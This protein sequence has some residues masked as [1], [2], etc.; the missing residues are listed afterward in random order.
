MNVSD[1]TLERLLSETGAATAAQVNELKTEEATSGRSLQELAISGGLIS[2]RALAEKYAEM[3]DVAFVEIDPKT[4]K[5][6]LLAL[7]P[8]PVAQR[9][10]AV[11]Y[12][13]IEDA[14]EGTVQLISYVAM[15]DPEDIQAVGFLKKLLGNSTEITLATHDNIQKILNGLGGNVDKKLDAVI[16]TQRDEDPELDVAV[17]EADIKEDSPTAQTVNLLIE[18]AIRS[19]ASDIHI[20]PN[21]DGVRV[22]YRIDGVLKEANRLPKKVLNAVVSRIKILANL[23]ID[24]RR[25]PQDG[26]F[27]TIISNHQYA[28]RVST[29]PVTEGE[30]VVMRILD[31]SSTAP[32][33][34]QLGYWG[35]SSDI[36]NR[37]IIQP[38]GMI[39]VTGPT[40]S[41]KSTSLFS[42][43]NI[44]NKPEINIS[45]VEDPVEYRV[46]GVNQ[47]Q[48][49]A[50]AGMTFAGGLRALLRQDP[51]VIMVG[52][53]RDTETADLAV[54]AA[55]TGHL[56]LSTLH[57]NNAATTLPRLLD[58][59]IEPF[60]IAS[61]IRAVV[62]Q[63]LVR[64]LDKSTREPYVP[65][66]PEL[67]ALAK[68]FRISTPDDFKRLHALEIIARDA[69]LGSDLPLSTTESGITTLYRP[70][71][72]P[73]S[74]SPGDGYGGRLGIYEV[75]ENSEKL[76][77]LIVSN[78]TADLI[79]Q[80]AIKEGM[81]SMQMDGLVK[82]LRGLTS[83]E[84]VLR[85]TRS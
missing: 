85:V 44:L 30:K 16:Q 33:P 58:M 26:R 54:Q 22:R 40:G 6:E 69:G 57:T 68:S 43:L 1:S 17:S 52:E 21:E 3:I 28:L 74:L 48:V 2:E 51:N 76:Q 78:A 55:L 5:P 50:K 27:K 13:Q 83:I 9:Y 31:E 65:S 59:G 79:E 39:L 63:R 11:V 77:Q 23:K 56:V 35:R 24:E 4:I 10:G 7:I 46:K 37:A 19:G 53:I 70:G 47:T 38:N 49:N 66:E 36:L 32:T 25:V 41:G 34:G 61:T 8:E 14:T 73:D 84:E 20:E 82:S 42:V 29:L 62:G 80:Q 75:I 81:V 12:R 71:V 67:T 64:Q 72:K 15:E 45:T 60:L 18:Y